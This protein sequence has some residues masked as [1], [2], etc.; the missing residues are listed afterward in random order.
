MRLF[1]GLLALLPVGCQKPL[2]HPEIR[3]VLA[4]QA[5]AWN[6]G[7]LDAY[8]K[9]YWNSDEL[10]YASPGE[11]V[12]SWRALLQQYRNTYPA[13]SD[14]GKLSFEDVQVAMAGPDAAE[15]SGR[16]RLKTPHSPRCGR[17]FLNMRRIDG[18]WVIVKHYA[19]EGG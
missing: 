8:M 13:C 5:A 19:L 12:H 16:Y 18:S 4:G 2:D 3:A 14:M 11:Q 9:A 7:S 1:I 10:L 17:F 15:V 6:R